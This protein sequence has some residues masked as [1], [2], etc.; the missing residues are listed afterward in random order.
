MRI[1][2]WREGALTIAFDGAP[3]PIEPSGPPDDPVRHP[4]LERLFLHLFIE[5]DP[6]RRTLSFG[7]VLNA[8]CERL[9]VSTVHGGERYRAVFSKGALVTLLAR[10]RCGRPL[11]TSWLTFLPDS[12]IITGAPLTAAEAGRVADRV[13]AS[14]TAV[15]IVVE[16]RAS[17]EAD[18]L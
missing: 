9:V 11:G 2:L 7:A 4:A 8:L 5:T 16:D 13:G 17:E 12:G 6:S 3:L 15:R 1:I 14:T 18:W 10:I